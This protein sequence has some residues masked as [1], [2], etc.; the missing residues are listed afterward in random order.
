VDPSACLWRSAPAMWAWSPG[1][2]TEGASCTQTKLNDEGRRH[3]NSRIHELHCRQNLTRQIRSCCIFKCWRWMTLR[4][5][6]L[7]VV[8]VVAGLN[9]ILSLAA[10]WALAAAGAAAAAHTAGTANTVS[11]TWEETERRERDR[12]RETEREREITV[13][14]QTYIG[15]MLM[16]RE[17][18][19]VYFTEKM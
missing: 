6:D 10:L 13:W 18:A 17:S 1:S 9:P 3:N 16:V 19:R 5:S 14:D 15:L 4:T 12:D 7:A 11:V 2:P 8:G